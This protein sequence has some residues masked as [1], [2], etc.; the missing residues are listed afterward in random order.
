MAL[1]GAAIPWFHTVL[2]GFYW[3]DYAGMPRPP[4]RDHAYGPTTSVL[5]DVYIYNSDLL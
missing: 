3:N 2:G 4:K 1:G 5:A